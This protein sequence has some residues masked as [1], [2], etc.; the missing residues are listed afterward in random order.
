MPEHEGVVETA[1]G[2]EAAPPRTVL[3][4]WAVIL[5]LGAIDWA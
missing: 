2:I 3:L 4:A 5:I 1:A